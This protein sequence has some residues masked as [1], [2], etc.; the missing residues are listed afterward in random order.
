MGSATSRGES[1]KWRLQSN[2]KVL[3]EVERRVV[4][5]L[6]LNTLLLFKVG[7]RR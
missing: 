1:C 4:S 5:F 6:W 7:G 2:K 3:F